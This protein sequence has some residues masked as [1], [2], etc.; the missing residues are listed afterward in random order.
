MPIQN[1]I[2]N[3]TDV[4]RSV[5]FYTKFLDAEVVDEPTTARAVLDLV[6]A[7]IEL[8]AV[9]PEAPQ[10]T[11][12][13]DD[14]QK[15]FRHL[16]FKVDSVDPRAEVLKAADV[17]FHLDPL[18]AEGGV[19][20]C[21]FFDPDGTLLEFVEGDLQYASIL[22]AAGVAK[23]RALGV[24]SRP[25]FDHVAITVEDRAKTDAFYRDRFGFSFIGTI[26]QPSDQRGFSIG[27][28]KS[29]DTVIEVFTYQTA[30][31]DRPPQLNA[32]G[33]GYA[34]LFGGDTAGLTTAATVDDPQVY[35][36]ND[37]FPFSVDSALSGNRA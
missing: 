25:R 16:G 19:R 3:V 36:D 21:F 10:S 6:T 29:G 13:A 15:G 17:R 12:V 37:G 5:D 11:W 22:D 26:E 24:P 1:L 23:E 35:T 18:N 20:I 7:T 27:Y 34:V 28:L 32:P 4:Q 31:H 14:L 9:R 8:R 2:L 30:K 33:F